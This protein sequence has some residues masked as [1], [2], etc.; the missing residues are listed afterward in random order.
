M[1]S[2]WCDKKLVLEFEQK[3]VMKWTGK[4]TVFLIGPSLIISLFMDRGND[5]AKKDEMEF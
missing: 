4:R 5:S 1:C 3:F 2:I